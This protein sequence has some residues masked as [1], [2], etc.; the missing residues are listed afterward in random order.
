MRTLK[1]LIPIIL[2]AV[3]CLAPPIQAEEKQ[4]GKGQTGLQNR[5]DFGNA[6]VLGQSIKSGAVYLLHRKQSELKGM[7]D[8]REH[9]RHEIMEDYA[10]EDT[11]IVSADQ[12]QPAEQ[13]KK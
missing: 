1:K 12:D 4:D 7:I 6:Y 9:Y 5:I 13:E 11:A 3:L 8:I 10:L 2:L